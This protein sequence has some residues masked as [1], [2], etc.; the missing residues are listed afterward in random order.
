MVD[1]ICDEENAYDIP[2]G[3]KHQ[4]LI[5]RFSART[6]RYMSESLYLTRGR[7]CSHETS[8]MLGLLEREYTDMCQGL[9][10]TLTGTIFRLNSIHI[11]RI[12]FCCLILSN[13]LTS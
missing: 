2:V 3:L 12:D 8:G 11:A 10:E 6:S 13:R 5:A 1:R 4:L 7:I 9:D